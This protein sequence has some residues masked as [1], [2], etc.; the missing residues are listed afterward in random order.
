MNS[1]HPSVLFEARLMDIGRQRQARIAAFIERRHLLGRMHRLWDRSL[2]LIDIPGLEEIDPHTL[3]KYL[4]Q[5]QRAEDIG[6][7]SNC[8][9]IAYKAVQ[10]GAVSGV[11][12][13]GDGT[14]ALLN[15]ASHGL[16]YDPLADGSVVG[17]D[18]TARENISR[19]IRGHFDVMA[20]RAPNLPDLISQVGELYGGDWREIPRSHI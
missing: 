10:V 1:E 13:A 16:N 4:E 15:F 19:H 20:L 6:I 12:E 17:V 8:F 7:T 2:F 11:L 18:F 3:D 5:R 9:E 14:N